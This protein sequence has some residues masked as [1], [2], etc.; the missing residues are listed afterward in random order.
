MSKI[1]YSNVVGSLMYCMVCT[2]PDIVYVVGTIAQFMSSLDA[3]HCGVVKRI[4]QYLQ[5]T[6]T[7]QIKFKGNMQ[8]SESLQNLYLIGWCD[9]DWAS[10]VGIHK[11]TT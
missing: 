1:T 9:A 10:D 2:K 4:L 11:S 7:F 8:K 5:G 3:H 6:K